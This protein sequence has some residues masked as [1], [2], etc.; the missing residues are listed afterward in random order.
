MVDLLC[1]R[2]PEADGPSDEAPDGE[3]LAR[4]RVGERNLY[5]ILY[6]RHAPL[7]T[8]FARSLLNNASDADDVVA[9]VFASTLSALERGVGPADTFLPYVMNSIRHECYR[10][11]RRAQRHVSL[12]N[13]AATS[14]FEA[15]DDDPFDALD[16]A[17]VVRAAMM[18]VP[19]ELRA[20]L[21]HTAVE[22]TPLAA[23]A[24]ERGRSTAAT[25]M[26]AVRARK[27]LRNAYL[28]EHLSATN[29]DDA[30]GCREIRP[31]LA[32]YVRG[33]HGKRHRRRVNEHLREC[34]ACAT[35]GEELRQV[36]K[37]LRGAAL[38]PLLGGSTA[39]CAWI[40]SHIAAGW[41]AVVTPL[42]SAPIIATAAAIAVPITIPDAGWINAR[43]TAAVITDAPGTVATPPFP[44]VHLMVTTGP[45][46]SDGDAT[47]PG[48]TRASRTATVGPIEDGVA[49]AT[50]HPET[51]TPTVAASG[52]E[53]PRSDQPPPQSGHPATPTPPTEPDAWSQPPKPPNHP[54][55]SANTPQREQVPPEPPTPPTP[56]AATAQPAPNAPDGPRGSPNTARRESEPPESSQQ[57]TS[58]EPTPPHGSAARRDL[59]PPEPAQQPAASGHSSATPTPANGHDEMPPAASAT[60]AHDPSASQNR[61]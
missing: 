61:N 1:W 12:A 42:T 17:A 40:K 45:P 7:A 20:V 51:T 13:G 34:D 5:G 33:S 27:A 52:D 24:A 19:M 58:S 35:A 25:A 49:N 22:G 39:W 26:T 9:E 14:D 6:T 41:S 47:E 10:V 59:A 23:V 3:L 54:G 29:V 50:A 31:L 4:V 56:G 46:G 8:R 21:W 55:G 15:T 11:N 38:F 28:H 18:S 48:D 2:T 60:T 32:G 44:V 30:P 36:N 37:V 57:S 16:E 43:P 53:T